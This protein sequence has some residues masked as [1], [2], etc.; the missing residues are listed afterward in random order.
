MG[1]AGDGGSVW[2]GFI[3]LLSVSLDVNRASRNQCFVPGTVG[4]QITWETVWAHGLC[5]LGQGFPQP[6]RRVEVQCAG[7]GG[8]QSGTLDLSVHWWL[9]GDHESLCAK[10]GAAEP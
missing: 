7:P 2:V 10:Q 6:Q 3:Q 1:A 8:S 5:H 9:S 4:T